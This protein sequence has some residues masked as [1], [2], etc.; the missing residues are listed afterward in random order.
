MN[1]DYN[2]DY[3]NVLNVNH[4]ASDRD[5]KKSYYK[6]A[7]KLHPDKNPNGDDVEFKKIND[8]YEILGDKEK[9]A[10]YDNMR[11][12]NINTSNIFS[13]IDDIGVHTSMHNIN[14]HIFMSRGFTPLGSTTK[15]PKPLQII[16]DITIEDIYECKKKS[17]SFTK[18]VPCQTCEGL[19]IDKLK[20]MESKHDYSCSK[21]R[22]TGVIN[23]SQVVHHARI[24]I[25]IECPQCNG[26][27]IMVRPEIQCSDCLGKGIK[28]VSDTIEY[29]LSSQVKHGMVIR[30]DNFGHQLNLNTTPGP[31]LLFINQ[32]EHSQF[33]RSQNGVDLLMIQKI[34]LYYALGCS[35]RDAIIIKTI[36]NK[37]IK[38]NIPQEIIIKPGDVKEVP[39]EAR[40]RRSVAAR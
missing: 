27:R 20:Y 23:I 35:K 28:H 30:V 37:I 22:G 18:I 7:Q 21:C 26:E 4:D 25:P 12:M 13:D 29:Q 39:N 10:I 36:S 6:L 17:V 31:L 5:I 40:N 2:T 34:S 24:A 32:V 3:Y 16:L 14:S 8:A 1:I 19:R 33:R 38:I 11:E 15:K 9:R